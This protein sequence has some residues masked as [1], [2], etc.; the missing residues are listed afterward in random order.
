[1]DSSAGTSRS[2]FVTPGL[3]ERTLGTNAAST[4]RRL[5]GLSRFGGPARRVILPV[6]ETEHDDE[7]RSPVLIGLSQMGPSLIV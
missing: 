2:H 5:G 1:M 6:E 4:G 7:H 3:S